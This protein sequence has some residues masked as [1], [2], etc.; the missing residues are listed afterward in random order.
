MDYNNKGLAFSY[1]FSKLLEIVYKKSVYYSGKLPY[2]YEK[3]KYPID[4]I[5]KKIDYVRV[6][7]R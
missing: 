2:E 7:C 6:K 3:M 4:E 1:F 5:E